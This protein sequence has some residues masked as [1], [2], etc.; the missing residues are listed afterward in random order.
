MKRNPVLS[1]VISSVFV[2]VSHKFVTILDVISLLCLVLNFWILLPEYC[3]FLTC[4]F[5]SYHFFFIFSN[6][7]LVILWFFVTCPLERAS[8]TILRAELSSKPSHEGRSHKSSELRAHLM[9][10]SEA[11]LEFFLL[12]SLRALLPS[13]RGFSNWTT[14]AFGPYANSFFVFNH[15]AFGGVSATRAFRSLV[16]HFGFQ[17]D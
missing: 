15:Y 5:R 2:F 10:L 11:R 13:F 17:A 7:F 14:A 12:D 16:L 1:L 3:Q 8:Q 9:A 6:S 4:F